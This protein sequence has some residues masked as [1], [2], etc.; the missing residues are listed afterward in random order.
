MIGNAK[1]CLEDLS[2][3][4]HWTGYIPCINFMLDIC[5]T[6][7]M[8]KTKNLQNISPIQTI[9]CNSTGTFFL[10]LL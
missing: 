5:K 8:S 2:I 9:P 1:V 3:G 6:E 10:K 7:T 4:A